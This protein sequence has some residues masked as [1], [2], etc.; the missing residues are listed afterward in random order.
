MRF[1]KAAVFGVLALGLTLA[2]AGP[3][4]A[5]AWKSRTSPLYGYEDGK[6]FGKTY[7]NFYNDGSVTA[8]STTFQYDLEPG[9]N[10]V[11]METDFYFLEWDSL[12]NA[13]SGGVCWRFDTSKQADTSDDARWIEHYRARNLHPYGDAARGG[14]DICEIQSFQNDPCSAHAWPSFEY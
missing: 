10:D 9:G 4:S 1:I 5:V 7:G 2:L 6:A 14:I 12:C 11:R 13:G 3:A 8:H